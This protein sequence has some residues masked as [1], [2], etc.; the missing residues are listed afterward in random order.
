MT[1]PVFVS[2]VHRVYGTCPPVATFPADY[3][4]CYGR[5]G[6]I[7]TQVAIPLSGGLCSTLFHLILL[8][9]ARG[10]CYLTRGAMALRAGIRGPSGTSVRSHQVS[11]REGREGKIGVAITTLR[12]FASNGA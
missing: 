3:R 11:S 1:K 7:G 10:G 9:L 5:C 4:S 8:A 6:F 2:R 12:G